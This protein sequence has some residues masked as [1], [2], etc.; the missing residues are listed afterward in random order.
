MVKLHPTEEGSYVADRL[1]RASDFADKLGI[2]NKAEWY[3]VL[4]DEQSGEW[5]VPNGCIGSRWNNEGKWNLKCEDVR[6]G[7]EFLPRLS[8][9]PHHTKTVDVLFPY[10]G[11]ETYK[12]RHWNATQHSDV[13]SRKIPVIEVETDK[14]TVYCTN[15]FDLM[16][17]NYGVER[18]LNDSNAASDYNDD[19]PYTPK[20][21]EKITGVPSER[22][23]AVARQFASNAEKTEGKSMGNI[24][25]N[26][27]LPQ[28]D[29]YYE[30][31]TFDFSKLQGKKRLK[32]P[33][34]ARPYSLITGEKME[35]IEYGPNWE[36]DLAGPFET[37]KKDP[38]MTRIG[39]RI[40]PQCIGS[41]D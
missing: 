14:G 22:V 27:Y 32:T 20:W 41:I 7:K 23:I 36:D 6:T 34:S 26:P 5:V 28:V 30:P 12:N 39:L 1:L 18:G 29:D 38:N 4:C 19:I 8:V 16:L 3:P 13:L 31:F 33:P 10:F 15:V 25:S 24:F 21:Q 2:K 35:K 11:G 40:V 17:A 37:R 9:Y